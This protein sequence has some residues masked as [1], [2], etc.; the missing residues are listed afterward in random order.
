[1]RGVRAKNLS[2][3]IGSR[4][5]VKE[6]D[7]EMEP[8]TLWLVSGDCGTGKTTLARVVVG[9]VPE[10]YR[11]YRVSGVVE[12]FGYRPADALRRGLVAY[13]PQDI[14]LATLTTS[15]AEE[16]FIYGLHHRVPELR[17]LVGDLMFREIRKLSAGERFRVLTGLS[18]LLNKKLVVVDEP[19]GYLDPETLG[20]VLEVLRDYAV[21]SGSVVVV[22]DHKLGYYASK[23]DGMIDLGSKT[24]CS[25]SRLTTEASRGVLLE[26][27]NLGFRYS[28]TKV[29]DGL[30]LRV[31]SGMVVAVVGSNG[32]GKTTLLRVLLGLLKPSSGI[33]RRHYRRAF[34]VPQLSSYWM[35]GDVVSVLKALGCDPSVIGL[36]GVSNTSST[37]LS[38]GEIRR[39]SVYAG[40]YGTSD[41]VVVDEVSLGLDDTSIECVSGAFNEARRA[42]K[43][44]VFSTHDARVARFLGPDIVVKLS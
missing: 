44:V 29:F 7:L 2:V 14:S 28:N 39:L 1:M 8:G 9:L 4:E 24:R 23:V 32:S 22:L 19:S 15:A 16:L 43:S 42:G 38:L 6:L 3:W 35:N 13:V 27:R 30:D 17:R 31:D 41:L 26:A 40:I 34:Y 11:G 20:E 21:K 18:L 33:V 25:N 36:V 10:L 5:V 37:A 12:V